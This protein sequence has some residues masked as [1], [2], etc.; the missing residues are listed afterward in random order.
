MPGLYQELRRRNIFKVG[1][2]YVIVGWIVVWLFTALEHA[3]GWPHWT[4]VFFKATVFA[5]L[6][7]V[8]MFGWAY[9]V[10]PE[11]MKK[12]D[13][14]TPEE[15]ITPKTG[16]RLNQVIGIGAAVAGFLLLIDYYGVETVDEPIIEG[17]DVAISEP[18]SEAGDEA[19]DV[20]LA[21][22]APPEEGSDRPRRTPVGV[23]ISPD[24]PFVSRYVEVL[25]SR[26]H[27]VEEGEGDPILFLHGNPTSSYLWRN[28]IPHVSGQGRAIAV[29]LIGMGKSDKPD[30]DY[31]FQDHQRY[32]D[33]FIAALELEN[34]TLVIHDWGSALGLDY[35]SRHADNILGIAMMEAIIPPSAPSP[36][37][38]AEGSLFDMLRDTETG[39][40]LIMEDNYFVEVILPG[41]VYRGLTEAEMEHYRAPYPDAESRKP[42]Y[43]WPQEVPFG[44]GPQRNVDMVN[45]I[46]GWL[47]ETDT[48]ILLFYANPG[49]IIPPQAAEWLAGR[50]RNIETRYLGPGYHFVQEDH[51]HKIGLGLADW[52]RR[53][54]KGATSN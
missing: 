52:R 33:A 30:L 19:E 5:G 28:V 27:Y 51:P 39:P 20:S 18:V 46:G 43:V 11:G 37:P 35:A 4:D 23:E 17:V 54:V 8:L 34:I 14:I 24:F 31:T 21:E 45:R 50:L 22:I 12:S 36:E 47:L 32:V 6:P 15:S 25:G 49:T 1:V 29:D 13:R 9:E 2:A 16:H 10:T 7:A 40:E 41:A 44:D 53:L 3:L 38:P 48:P 42:V 26:M